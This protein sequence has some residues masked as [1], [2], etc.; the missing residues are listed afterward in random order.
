MQAQVSACVACF[1]RMTMCESVLQRC[2]MER[3]LPWTYEKDRAFC[4]DF[5]QA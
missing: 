1:A 3:A 4:V 5:V 2:T